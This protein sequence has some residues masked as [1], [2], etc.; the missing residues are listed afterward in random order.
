MDSIRREDGDASRAPAPVVIEEP[1]VSIADIKLI[2]APGIMMFWALAVVVFLQFF[3][4]YV[5]NDSLAWTEE[6]ARYMLILL[7][8]LGSVSAMKR[9]THIALEFLLRFVP[10]RVAK[11]LAITAELIS[12]LGLGALTLIGIQLIQTT[13]QKMV[14]LPVPKAWIYACCVLALAVMTAYSA[15]WLWRKIKRTPEETVAA[16]D[17]GLTTD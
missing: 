1:E 15:V 10:P 2:D 17:H 7:T 9:G 14:V 5:L 4:R 11:G 3:T 16:L 6:V 12:F 8:F 13:R